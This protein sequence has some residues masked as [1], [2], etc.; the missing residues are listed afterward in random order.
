M[1][2]AVVCCVFQADSLYSHI[3]FRCL[4]LTRLRVT[5]SLVLF[6]SYLT[7]RLVQ[8]LCFEDVIDNSNFS[9]RLEQGGSSSSGHDVP[10]SEARALHDD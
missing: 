5:C 3:F 2:L 6:C 4:C 7:R 9:M 1:Q 8:C 10:K